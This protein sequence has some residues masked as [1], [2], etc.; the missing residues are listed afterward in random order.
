M[1]STPQNNG[2]CLDW[3]PADIKAA[4]QKKGFVCQNSQGK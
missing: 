1:G 4:L 2:V 3:H